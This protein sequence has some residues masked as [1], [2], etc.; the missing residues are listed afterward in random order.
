[1]RIPDSA[2]MPLEWRHEAGLE[3]TVCEE[4]EFLEIAEDFSNPCEIFREALSNAFDAGASE[5][6]IKLTTSKYGSRSILQ[7]EFSDNGCGMGRDQLQAFFDLG[8]STSRDN[9]DTI[10]EKG[11]GTKIYYKSSRIEVVTSSAGKQL[12]ASVAN[13]YDALAN[14]NKPSISVSSRDVNP[15][16]HGTKITIDDYNH[17]IRDRFTHSYLKDYILWFTKMGSIESQLGHQKHAK[18][19]V[20]LQGV[21]ADA[22]ETVE[23]GHIFPEES[24]DLGK[25]LDVFGVDA[26]SRYV[27]KWKQSGAL[28]NFPDVKWDAVFYLEGDDAKRSYNPMIRGKGRTL[29]TGMYSVQE[30]YG[31]WLCKD[32]IPI[33]RMNEWVTIKGSEFTRFHAF[34]NC[35]G[36]RLTANRGSVM[37]T[38]PA[39]LED[40]QRE[41]VQ[42][43]RDKIASTSEF[44]DLEWLEGQAAAFINADKDERDFTKRVSKLSKRRAAGFKGH[45]FLEPENEVGVLSLV[46]ALTVI[47]SSALPFKI[48]DYTTYRGNDA[49]A[50]FST[51]DLPLEKLNIGYIE[52][53]YTLQPSFNHLFKHL[54]GIVCWDTSVKDGDEVVDVGD[55]RRTM[56]IVPADVAKNQRTRYFLEDP[57]KPL[58]IEVFVLKEY[59]AEQLGIT[60]QFREETPVKKI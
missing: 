45:T 13:P 10:G 24:K 42:F 50:T 3:P 43:Y 40:I 22:P 1:M 7:I 39:V 32:H 51:E 35:Q 15:S 2:P 11:H 53:K 27:K 57:R 5:I 12:R 34:V 19:R 52:F 56:K 17:S 58:R 30:R 28:K 25:L 55:S 47:D 41:V 60:F 14:G 49:L 29:Q 18:A 33:Q 6:T 44:T 20:Y 26:P 4:R 21:D 8:N 23:F 31:L 46:T 36:F 9:N 38:P 16:E 37:N 54:R 48:L 59:L